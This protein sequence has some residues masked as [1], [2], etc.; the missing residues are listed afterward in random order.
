MKIRP[1]LYHLDLKSTPPPHNP[2][3][4]PQVLCLGSGPQ[5]KTQTAGTFTHSNRSTSIFLSL[6]RYTASLRRRDALCPK[7]C[8]RMLLPHHVH[9]PSRNHFLT[10]PGITPQLKRYP[11][12]LES[13][14]LSVETPTA[15]FYDALSIVA[16]K[17]LNS[18][19]LSTDQFKDCFLARC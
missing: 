18:F 2:H 13:T 4:T 10:T 6:F 15:D 17:L 16:E 9:S 5:S 8:R 12:A 3:K 11:L 14:H 1:P 19:H 7:D